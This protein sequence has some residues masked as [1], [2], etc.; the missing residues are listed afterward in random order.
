VVTD[1]KQRLPRTE[2]VAFLASE[3]ASVE[4][5]AGTVLLDRYRLVEP[6]GEGGAAVVYRAEHTI[7]H[8]ALAVKILRPEHAARPDF[9]R[10]FLSEARTVARLRHDNIVD[11]VDIGRT[12]AGVVFCVME[13][14]EGEELTATIERD[15]PMPWARAQTIVLQI[16]G[17]LIAAHEAGVIHRDI[18]PSNCFRVQGRGEPDAIKVLDFGIAKDM[19]AAHRLTATGTIMGTAGYMPPEQA[20]AIEVDVR[21]DVYAVGAVLF[22][23][24][25]GR[26]AFDGDSFLD[27]LMQQATAAAPRVSEFV[28][29]VQPAVDDIVR[30]ALDADRDS[31]FGSMSE[32]G[33]AISAVGSATSVESPTRADVVPMA[34]VSTVVAPVASVAAPS[35]GTRVAGVGTVVAPVPPRPGG[36]AVPQPQP[37]VDSWP[38]SLGSDPGLGGTAVGPQRSAAARRHVPPRRRAVMLG[39]LLTLA[40][41]SIVA[42]TVALVATMSPATGTG[43]AE[44]RADTTPTPARAAAVPPDESPELVAPTQK[45]ERPEPPPDPT[46]AAD[47]GAVAPTHGDTRLTEHEPVVDG[48]PHPSAN[49][50]QTVSEAPR[51]GGTGPSVRTRKPASSS[52][53]TR[54][55]AGST[56]RR[57][58]RRLQRACGDKVGHGAKTIYVDAR[59]LP[60]VMVRIEPAY[61]PLQSCVEDNVGDLPLEFNEHF[62]LRPEAEP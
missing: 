45:S 21:A 47:T 60:N 46:I 6:L 48:T 61:A 38:A 50:E 30:R 49:A 19:S 37:Q 36:A 3:P 56:L 12:E 4:Q 54:A 58:R 18:K 9:V 28:S 10:R 62:T 44:V 13:W 43:A 1:E 29:G 33:R 15:G 16:C 31:R 24:L 55:G 25:T 23:L 41:L 59:L 17:A 32:L 53:V 11:V 42:M 7:M 57:L 34:S 5:L 2:E 14:L 51:V 27:V 39:I 26:P 52:A 8:K 20:R 22:E 40:G 35:A